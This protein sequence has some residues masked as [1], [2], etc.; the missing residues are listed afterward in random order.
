MHNYIK[1]YT[2]DRPSLRVMYCS[3]LMKCWHGWTESDHFE[4]QWKMIK[5]SLSRK[6]K[7]IHNTQVQLL[8]N[9]TPLLPLQ[10]KSEAWAQ[11][12]M[13]F[14][15]SRKYLWNGPWFCYNSFWLQNFILTVCLHRSY[16]NFSEIEWIHILKSKKIQST[17]IYSFYWRKWV[18]K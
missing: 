12:I 5:S 18:F 4:L 15:C 1:Y 14:W 7:R 6:K 16:H 3:A 9:L 13:E 17:L 2:I 8:F 10:L 11:M